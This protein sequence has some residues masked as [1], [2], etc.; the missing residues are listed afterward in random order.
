M[1]S[2]AR[3]LWKLV[4]TGLPKGQ[5]I[6]AIGI[7]RYLGNEESVQSATGPMGEKKSF[8][9]NKLD[10]RLAVAPMMDWTDDVKKCS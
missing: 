2:V 6:Q 3:D 1:D 4:Y 9:M 7:Q 8:S 5:M 10:R